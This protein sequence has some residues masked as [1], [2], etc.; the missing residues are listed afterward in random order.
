M[1]VTSLSSSG[2]AN[3]RNKADLRH[4]F[5]FSSDGIE[6]VEDGLPEVRFGEYLV[7]QGLID[8]FQL[9]RAL[10]LQDRTPG[11]QLGEAVARL[12]YAPTSA[13]ERLY[14]RF[15]GLDTIDL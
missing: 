4:Y 14:D 13:I 6:V 1:H 2:Y 15:Q 10:Q 11:V 5:E 9:F 12:G 8:R 7:D 3:A